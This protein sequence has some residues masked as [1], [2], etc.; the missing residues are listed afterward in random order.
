MAGSK[1]D[2]LYAKPVKVSKA[3]KGNDAA[4]LKEAR[5]RA[6][7]GAT[8]WGD[9]WKAAEDDLRFIAGE[10]WPSQIR[11]ERELEQRPCLTNNVLP[12]FI[13]RII[14][15][16]LQNRPAIKINAKSVVRVPDRDDESREEKP[17]EDKVLKISNV[18]GNKDYSLG[19]VFTGLVRNIEY[20]C[21]AESS[22]DIAFQSAVESGM[23]YLR[24]LTDYLAD[25]TFEQD[26]I[27]KHIENQ[28]SVTI[29]PSAKERDRSDMGWCLIDDSME[30][31]AFKRKY[32][33][34]SMDPVNS[35]GVDDLGSW[36]AE[37]TVRISEYFTRE[38]IVREVALLSDGRSMF[39]DE[40]EPVVDELLEKGISIER[41]RKINTFK[42]VW[43]KI[44]G[45]NVLE[46]P[47]DIPCS[48]IPVVP[49]WG[50]ALVIKKKFIL[51]S[52]VRHSKD[53]QRMANY[54][55]S[56]ATES[57]ALA[58]KAPF[59]ASE[60]QI[61]GREEEW[62]NANTK[63]YAVL[64]YTKDSP[65]DRGP[66][67]SQPASIP[68]AEITM[69]MNSSDKIKATMGMFDASLGAQSNE[70][71]GKAINARTKQGEKGNF[72]FVDNL[73]K[74]LVRVG[75]II[76]EMAPKT[77]DTERV[78]RLKFDD[79]TED[80]VTLNEQVFDDESGEWVTINDLNVAKYDVVVT[81]GPSYATQREEASE[82]MIRFAQ[83]V[84]AAAAIM[85]DLVAQ[86]QDWPGADTLSK[87]LKKI[88]PPQALT[89]EERDEIAKDMPK[90]E[91]PTPDQQVQMK[92]LEARTAE[93]ESKVNQSQADIAKAEADVAQAQ[94]DTMKAQ[95][96]TEDAKRQLALIDEGA[97]NGS[98]AYEKVRELV[99][100]AIAEIT[101][102]SE[103]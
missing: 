3:G 17:A 72:K 92:E 57:V 19:E 94:A 59:V 83:A 85:G 75:R 15:E 42:V 45:L 2:K 95:L 81:T 48:T 43:R 31:E 29:D 25:D 38:P 30:K 37:K 21:S 58:P 53:A 1:V 52:A 10:Q 28:F 78:A 71:S 11:S 76:V 26:I 46:G 68:A 54:W 51:L 73:S 44:T 69:A 62:Q 16:Q 55:D 22:Y 41:T 79:E 97:A 6:R 77:L 33:D 96:E 47:I 90:Q 67:R 103:A 60:G 4:L 7:D 56:A 50:K 87:R 74:S 18:A 24:V 89:Q 61:E 91:D 13:D 9:N 32:P 80:F 40:I 70:T 102:T 82:M 99:A 86:N 98:I 36:F 35:D 49:V 64:T 84:P 66:Q 34:A 8:Y 100:Q 5:E 14:G 65:N 101:Q 23:G 93:A 12:T 88:M 39:V 27:I 63:N 20:N